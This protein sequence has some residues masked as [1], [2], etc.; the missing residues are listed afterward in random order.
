ML[1]T[2]Y[3]KF[4]AIPLFLGDFYGSRDPTNNIKAMKEAS[5]STRFQLD[6]NVS[7]GNVEKTYVH[8]I[9]G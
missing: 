9:F 5:Y 1:H 2:P 8:I 3:G 7:H 6:K 4:L